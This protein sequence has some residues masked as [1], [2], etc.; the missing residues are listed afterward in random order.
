MRALLLKVH[1]IRYLP[2]ILYLVVMELGV[3]PVLSPTYLHKIGSLK[4]AD[5]V[6]VTKILEPKKLL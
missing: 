1:S 4:I 6:N 3:K 2:P 5:I